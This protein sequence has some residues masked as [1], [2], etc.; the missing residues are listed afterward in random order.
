MGV[1]WHAVSNSN[2]A[3]SE[4]S[5]D[6]FVVL[7]EGRAMLLREKPVVLKQ[8][9]YTKILPN[10]T[11]RTLADSM[12]TI[13]WP[14]GSVTRVKEN[15]LMRIDTVEYDPQSSRTDIFFT[16][17]KGG[18]W[19]N[20]IGYLS[21]DS[22][23]RQGLGDSDAVASVRGTVFEVNADDGYIRT[24]SHAVTVDGTGSKEATVSEGNAIN[25]ASLDEVSASLFD[26]QWEETNR[27]FDLEYIDQRIQE[28][29]AR[30]IAEYGYA[31][32]FDRVYAYVRKIFVAAGIVKSDLGSGTYDPQSL[33]AEVAEVVI[34]GDVQRLADLY[35]ENIGG[36]DT[37]KL[38][39]AEREALHEKLYALYR[40]VHFFDQSE[41]DLAM[42]SALRTMVS[43]TATPA[44]RDE[45]DESFA[46]YS[47][48]DLMTAKA[49]GYDGAVAL[50]STDLSAYLTDDSAGY[51]AIDKFREGLTAED[52]V[53]FNSTM[54][55]IKLGGKNLLE[56]L[57]TRDFGT[58]A[59][60]SLN[61]A[62]ESLKTTDYQETLG[63]TLTKRNFW[64]EFMN[65]LR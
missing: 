53:R 14:D 57:K 23:F 45:L 35:N 5:T 11:L 15:S 18:S 60:E 47:F 7:N 19:T 10:D 43:D 24:L 12:A 22:R 49:S 8:G 31:D 6:A 25:F 59:K 61:D 21:G 65:L 54:E 13:I 32:F 29:K 41:E 34:D 58:E 1:V 16:L 3:K 63:D 2:A 52:L 33:V 20:V 4:R 64:D 27:K 50:L 48:Y 30:I 28:T 9:E 62:M 26:K 17:K 39:P 36:L 46:R 44:E 51:A 55:S 37:S 38:A 40:D 56:L 42:K